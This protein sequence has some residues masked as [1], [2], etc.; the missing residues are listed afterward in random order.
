MNL[1][2]IPSTVYPSITVTSDAAP[3]PTIS[4]CI[5]ATA[6]AIF[7]Y[8]SIPSILAI[9]GMIV[10]TIQQTVIAVILLPLLGLLRP[11]NK[12]L[13]TR[14]AGTD[15]HAA[16]CTPC[17]NTRAELEDED[18]IDIDK[19]INDL[20]RLQRKEESTRIALDTLAKHLDRVHSSHNTIL[21]QVNAI[22]LMALEVGKAL[23]NAI[24]PDAMGATSPS[25]S[26]MDPASANPPCLYENPTGYIQW[27]QTELNR[28]KEEL[29]P[30]GI[31][32]EVTKVVIHVE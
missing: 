25:T 17:S 14:S 16:S 10:G 23:D 4:T 24:I 29:G 32:G 12:L 6:I 9:F 19:F 18:E 26:Y 2:A 22:G 31:E 15:N 13:G 5:I 7:V 21:A 28:I 3:E 8:V 11:C 30:V 20:D 1:P 27:A